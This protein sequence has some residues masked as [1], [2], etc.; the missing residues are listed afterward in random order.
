MIH[1]I[2]GGMIVMGT[3]YGIITGNIEAVGEGMLDGAQ[4][5]MS[6][7]LTMAAV[8]GLWCGMM[9][10]AGK[11]GLI[12]VIT[13]LMH[14][15]LRFLFPNIPVKHAAFQNLAVN[16]V[17]NLFGLAEAATP[18]GLRAIKAMRELEEER[19]KN[20]GKSGKVKAASNEMCTFLVI[21]IASLQLFPVSMIAFRSQYGSVNPTAIVAPAIVATMMSVLTGVIFCKIMCWKHR[22]Y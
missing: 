1:W 21:N 10:I 19:W 14:P 20:N 5:A 6:L 15:V 13:R 9:E 3:V 18:S 12:D 22:K 8:M 16:F 4:E 17:A 11:S 7:G 2:W